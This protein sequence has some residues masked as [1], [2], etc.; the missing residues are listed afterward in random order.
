MPPIKY[1][2][3]TIKSTKRTRPAPSS[4]RSSF[5][6]SYTYPYTVSAG[7]AYEENSL[8]RTAITG[9]SSS[10]SGG[11]ISTV[12]PTSGRRSRDKYNNLGTTWALE[13][14]GLLSAPIATG[15]IGNTVAVGHCSLPRATVANRV[16]C[17]IV[18]KLLIKMGITELSDFE[19]AI[20]GLIAGDSFFVNYRANALAIPSQYSFTCTALTTPFD[21]ASDVS[22]FFI[23]NY[24]TELEFLSISFIPNSTGAALLAATNLNLVGCYCHINSKSTLKIQN[25]TTLASAD[26]EDDVANVP[27]HGKAYYGKGTGA[28]PYTVDAKFTTA[29]AGFFGDDV[30][31]GLAKVPSEKWY[32][33]IVPPS[34]FENVSATGK[35]VLDPGHVKT[36]VL[37]ANM[38]IKLNELYRVMMNGI[39]ANATAHAKHKF[40]DFRFVLLEKMI[41]SE[42]GSG[43]NIIKVAFEVNLKLGAYVTMKR[44]TETAQMNSVANISAEI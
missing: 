40:G 39:T 10:K 18:K 11:F 42:A 21:V 4:S 14:G 35:V 41:M 31:G 34:H 19:R 8:S 44:N 17:A 30:F 15:S 20:D 9:G 23:T 43:T 38:R 22:T 32:Q 33:E 26:D 24:T 28:H 6:A 36:S 3:S 5:A 27:L 2:Q 1:V 13:K 16:W 25:R 29:A 7:Y 12:L 37:T